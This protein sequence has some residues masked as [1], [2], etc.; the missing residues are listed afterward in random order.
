MKQKLKIKSEL[1][2]PPTMLPKHEKALRP[3][4]FNESRDCTVRATSIACDAP[5][6]VVH[7]LFKKHGRKDNRGFNYEPLFRIH[8]SEMTK[9]LNCYFTE[10]PVRPCC[11]T[12][13]RFVKWYKTGSF[14]ITVRGHALCIKNGVVLDGSFVEN[15]HITNI[16]QVFKKPTQ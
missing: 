15:K 16:I 11:S 12:F 3:I 9:V 6:E 4:G 10:L 1:A 14:I 2:L 7:Y 13:N 8:K 5:Y